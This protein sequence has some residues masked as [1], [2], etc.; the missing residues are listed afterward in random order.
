MPDARICGMS[1]EDALT[2]AT[3]F[4]SYAHSDDDEGQIRR[5]KEKLDQAYKRH[6]GEALASFFDRTGD[7]RIEWGEEWRSKIST[8]ISGT[9]FF[10]PVISPSYL[11]SSMCREE[12]DEFAEKAQRSDLDELIMPMLWVPVFP[13]TAEEQRIF[14]A[15]QA[16]Q[17]VDWTQI[18]KLD[19]S[20]T[21]YRKLIDEMG[22]RLAKAARKVA[23]KP[24]VVDTP[25]AEPTTS[26]DNGDGPQGMPSQVEEP[27]GLVELSVEVVEQSNGMNA[28]LK[29]AFEALTRMQNVKVEPLGPDVS[30]AQRLFAFKQLATEITPYTEEFELKAKKAEEYARLLSKNVFSFVDLLSDPQN[31]VRPDFSTNVELLR[32]LPTKVQQQLGGINRVR[33]Q[34]SAI[35]RLSRDLR[36]PFSALERGFDSIDALLQLVDDW[37]VALRKLSED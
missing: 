17:W 19:E 4:W 18:R 34:I 22:E 21:E 37:G 1:D 36:A 30:N 32:E 27:P 10:I 23:T 6:R 9:T 13:E 14:D 5:L 16:R 33:S 2:T 3:A 15:A 29:E 35:G 20:S 24:E 26:D 28:N 8:T 25:D 12:F 11:K 7:N 31:Q